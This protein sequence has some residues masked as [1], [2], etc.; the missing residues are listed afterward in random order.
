MSAGFACPECGGTKLDAIEEKAVDGGVRRRRKCVGCHTVVATLEFLTGRQRPVKNTPGG[1]C[2]HG[3]PLT[4]DNVDV[5]VQNGNIRYRCRACQRA[6]NERM[7]RRWGQ[8][9]AVP[10]ITDEGVWCSG[11]SAEH[12]RLPREK[13]Y[14]ENYRGKL[15][16]RNLCHNCR[17]DEEKKRTRALAEDRKAAEAYKSRMLLDHVAAAAKRGLTVKQ[18]ATLLGVCPTSVYHWKKGK[19]PRHL[20]RVLERAWSHGVFAVDKYTGLK[21]L[22]SLEPDRRQAKRGQGRKRREVA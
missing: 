13:F 14:W 22:P 9:V 16:P 3:H 19:V 5:V 8:K 6:A 20:D 2:S 1:V 11:C 12:G 4:T 18:V 10:K 7:R 15:R 17:N 21:G